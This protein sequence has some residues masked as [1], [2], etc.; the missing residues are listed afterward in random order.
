MYSADPEMGHGMQF[1][2]KK[3]GW[4]YG[5]YLARPMVPA[6]PNDRNQMTELWDNFSGCLIRNFD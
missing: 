3:K 4:L 1:M 2:G 6:F 5:D